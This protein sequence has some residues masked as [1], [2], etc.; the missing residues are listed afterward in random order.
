MKTAV[1]P[2][3]FDPFT[4]GHEDIVDRALRSIADKVI[5]A[6][7][8]NCDKKGT[9][10]VEERMAA[11]KAVFADEPRVEVKSYEGL[12]IDFAKEAGASFLLRGVRNIKDFE[13]ERD[14]ADVNRHL[15]GIETV[16]LYSDPSLAHVSSSIVREL[17]SYGKDVTEF[18]AGK[19]PRTE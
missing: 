4:T 8:R 9:E 7:G 6:V 15:T 3:S 2:G 12:T 18:L 11:I 16:L 13:Y 1:F 10:T 19:H 17:A 5:I 14:I